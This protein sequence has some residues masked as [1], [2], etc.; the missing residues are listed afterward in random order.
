MIFILSKRLKILRQLNNLN[1]VELAKLLNVSK[2]SISNWENDNIQPS[3]EMLIKISKLFKV[4]TD[5]ILG[6]ECTNFEDVKFIDV[7]G[8]SAEK[9]LHLELLVNDLKNNKT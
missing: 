6:L 9:I 5:Y 3:I 7:T 8:L 4:S 1:Q 2:Q